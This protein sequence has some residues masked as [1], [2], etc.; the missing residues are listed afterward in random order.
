E[1]FVPVNVWRSFWRG[2]IAL[3]SPIVV[4]GAILAGVAT[5][6][7]IGAIAA[8]YALFAGVTYGG[9]SFKGIYQALKESVVVTAVIMYLIA[10]SSVM[11]WI[12][13]T[14]RVA[15][16]AANYIAQYVHS[17]LLGLLVINVLL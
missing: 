4:I 8:A 13:T 11:G 6:S 1:P 17:P 15:H 12:V 3:A 9:L 2:A 7:E 10:V 16:D 5:P 14:E